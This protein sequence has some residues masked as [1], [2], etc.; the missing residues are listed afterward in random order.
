MCKYRVNQALNT[1]LVLLYRN[2]NREHS[3]ISAIL[4]QF[5]LFNTARYEYSQCPQMKLK[6]LKFAYP[7]VDEIIL[8]DLL[9][10]NDHNVNK[11]IEHLHKFGYH[12]S[13][14]KVKISKLSETTLVKEAIDKLNASR[15]ISLPLRLKNHPNLEEQEN[16]IFLLSY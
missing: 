11:V 7:D 14:L 1:E 3:T 5:G 8:L 13:E 4:G 2:D 15:P 6:Y 10:N 16:S 9:F 12:S